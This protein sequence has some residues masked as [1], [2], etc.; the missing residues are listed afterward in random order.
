MIYHFHVWLR[1]ISPLIWRRLLL[2]SDQS[3]A[4]LHYALQLAFG[5]SDSHL[6][7][8]RIHGKEFGLHHMGGPIFDQRADEIRLVDF[9]FRIGERFLYEY[10]F[11]DCWEHRI[12]LERIRP[13]EPKRTYPVCIGGRRAVPLEDCGGVWAFQQYRDE[14][15]WRAQ[16]LLD[17]ISECV[18]ER[19]A[20]GLRDLVEE[21]PKLHTW[22]RL[23]R[24]DRR[25]ANRRPRQ[26]VSGD[27]EWQWPQGGAR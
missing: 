19:D 8:F 14:A 15:P 13:L 18:R 22:L 11:G 16:E 6:N 10:D 24:F 23:D 25:K 27:P 1:G 21:I 2:R 20:T 12:R 5:W 9:R 26:Y 7:R 17:E 4:D 3:I